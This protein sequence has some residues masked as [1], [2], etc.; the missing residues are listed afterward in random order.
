MKILVI[1]QKMIGDVLFSSIICENLKQWNPNI[2]IDFI[3]NRH[4]LPVIE[5]NPYIDEIIIFEDYF[6]NKKLSFINFLKKQNRKKYDIIIDAYGKIESILITLFSRGRIKIGYKKWYTKLVYSIL[7]DREIHKPKSG[8]QLSI[9][10]RLKLLEPIIKKNINNKLKPKIYLKN[11]RKKNSNFLSMKKEKLLIMISA[12]GSSKQKTYPTDKM[13]M[14]LDY[15]VKMHPVKLILNYIPNQ[16]KEI[17]NILKKINP[18]TKEAIIQNKTPKS[19]KEYILTVSNCNAIVG[20]EGGAINIAKALDIPSFSIFS[21]Q[22]NP[23]VWYSKSQKDALVHVKNFNNQFNGFKIKG[24]EI[25][26]LYESFDFN[27][28]QKDLSNFIKG[29]Q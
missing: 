12:L 25:K 11:D 3:A 4:T 16:R 2:R 27:Y 8:V 14:L 17:I 23:D 28:F 22:I 24:G 7:I 9:I 6:R 21:P 29:L 13:V 10:N 26:K 5:N 20:N 18:K 19:L 1:Q 15:L